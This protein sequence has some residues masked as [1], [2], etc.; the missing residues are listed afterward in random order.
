M[1]G[2]ESLPACLSGGVGGIMRVERGMEKGGRA[3][4]NYSS[5]FGR[6][7]VKHFVGGTPDG[8]GAYH[9]TPWGS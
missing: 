7:G 9:L 6:K 3:M 8:Q 2:A 5:G 4:L 1:P